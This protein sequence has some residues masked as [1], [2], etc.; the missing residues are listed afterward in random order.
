MKI[1]KWVLGIILLLI[2]IFFLLGVFTPSVSYSSEITVDKSVTESWSVMQD[3]S[4]LDQWI[5]GYVKSE[6]LSGTP[7]TVGAVSNIHV[8]ND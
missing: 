4:K 8:M 7:G 6:Q 1:L 3:E 2:I 5:T